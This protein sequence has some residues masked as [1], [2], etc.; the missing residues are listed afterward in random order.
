MKNNRWIISALVLVF[1]ATLWASTNGEKGFQMLKIPLSPGV[2]AMGG[3]GAYYSSDA[4]NFVQNPVAGLDFIGKTITFS[5]NSWLFDTRL[6]SLAYRTSNRISSFGIAYRVLDYG[7][8]ERRDEVGTEVL[9]EFHPLDLSVIANYARRINPNHSI[10]I[11]MVGLYEKIDTNS[12]MGVAF[13]VGYLYKTMLPDFHIMAAIKNI[14]FTSK[15]D[16]E[17]ISLPFSSEISLMKQ[18]TLYEIKFSSEAKLL[19]HI[20]DSDLKAAVGTMANIYRVFNLRA[21]YEFN[22][23]LKHFTTGFGIHYQR[24]MVDYSF[25]PTKEDLNSVH[26]FAVSYLF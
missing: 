18:F 3:T 12:S 14:G 1:G 26:M 24:V 21:G 20:D 16:K 7:K 17:K 13:D 2:S 19:Y 9:G 15:M 11:N 23:D 5:H 22:H 4:L 8:F 6:N 25:I 10:G